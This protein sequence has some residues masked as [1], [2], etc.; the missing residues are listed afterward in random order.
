MSG[1]IAECLRQF[2]NLQARRDLQYPVTKALLFFH[3]RAAV[4]D[5]EAIDSL[6]SEASVAEDVT[7]TIFFEKLHKMK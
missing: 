7:V 5:H 6:S 4:I 3:N 1:N 2:E